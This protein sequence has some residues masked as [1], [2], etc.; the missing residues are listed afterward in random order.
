MEWISHTDHS[1]ENHGQQSERRGGDPSLIWETMEI[2][3]DR[4]V[5]LKLCVS[6]F[7]FLR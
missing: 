4:C 2:H 1:V 3:P 5:V 6:S 7:C